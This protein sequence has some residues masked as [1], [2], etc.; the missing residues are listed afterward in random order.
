MDITPHEAA[1]ALHE[2]HHTQRMALRSAPPMFPAWYLTAVWVSVTA[3]QAA[4]EVL[5]GISAAIGVVV[6]II[7]LMVAVLKF[8]HDLQ[9]LPLRPHRSVVDP[10]AWAG[11]AGWIAGT[12]LLCFALLGVFLATGFGYPRTGAALLSLAVVA[13]TAPLLPR[14]MTMRTA[15]R[16]ERT[17]TAPAGTE[18]TAR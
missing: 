14:W 4:T 12:M 5:T 18:T 13:V 17:R 8:L 1:K 9:N 16:M 7:G 3:I 11:L 6:A 15:L 10:W 2:V